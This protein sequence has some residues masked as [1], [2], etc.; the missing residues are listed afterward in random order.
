MKKTTVVGSESFPTVRDNI[1]ASSAK[2]QR[3]KCKC[4]YNR[5]DPAYAQRLSI[6]L[7]RNDVL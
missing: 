2:D 6:Q 3:T 7:L 1:D 4:Y 5:Q